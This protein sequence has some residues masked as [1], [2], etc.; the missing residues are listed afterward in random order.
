MPTIVS[1]QRTV[2]SVKRRIQVKNFPTTTLTPQSAT[3]RCADHH[4]EIY[5]LQTPPVMK[6]RSCGAVK[7][8]SHAETRWPAGQVKPKRFLKLRS[9][10]RRTLSFSM[11]LIF[12]VAVIWAVTKH[13]SRD[14]SSQV[15]NTGSKISKLADLG[16]PIHR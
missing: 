10:L 14:M 11:I 8:L 12:V 4:M 7:A 9:A 2:G 6:C 5:P 16:I 13:L 3:Q 15:A 1:G